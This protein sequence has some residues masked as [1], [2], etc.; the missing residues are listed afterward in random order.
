MVCCHECGEL[1]WSSPDPHSLNVKRIW[2]E[3][4]IDRLQPDGNKNPKKIQDMSLAEI[5]AN[6][7]SFRN[8]AKVVQFQT[9]YGGTAV[10]LSEALYGNTDKASVEKAQAIQDAFFKGAPTMEA[11]IKK[12]V[13]DATK[14]GY[15]ETFLGYRRH[16]PDLQLEKPQWEKTPD[17]PEDAKKWRCFGQKD[18]NPLIDDN[19]K[20]K[21]LDNKFCPRMD[22][23]HGC[24]V[25]EACNKRYGHKNQSRKKARAE[26]QCYN[27]KIQGGSADDTNEALR[28]MRVL[29][30]DLAAKNPQWNRFMIVSQIYDAIYFLCPDELVP[31]DPVTAPLEDNAFKFIRE[32]M[33]FTGPER[34]VPITAEIEPPATDWSQIH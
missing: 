28:K 3:E 23:G 24:P 26:R 11:A 29:R 15:V 13:A 20:K 5:K 19:G 30:E 14:I 17:L 25:R 8:N 31:E 2:P 1:A 18:L 12:T 9:L 7:G 22:D 6:A 27:C 16:L 32:T 10:A 34:F 33:E 21:Y 4:E